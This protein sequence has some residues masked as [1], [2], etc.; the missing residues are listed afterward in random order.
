M[1]I[2]SRVGK[3]KFDAILSDCPARTAAE[4]FDVSPSNAI[5]PPVAL[6]EDILLVWYYTKIGRGQIVLQ[7][8]FWRGRTCGVGKLVEKWIQPRCLRGA[9]PAVYRR[10][11][12]S[13]RFV[14]LLVVGFIRWCFSDF[15]RL[16]RLCQSLDA[17]PRRIG[18]TVAWVP[19]L[20]LRRR[21]G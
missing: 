10:P 1:R 19:A 6:P 12:W 5:T 18:T 14:G 7:I 20:P 3:R 8:R 9:W 15:H 13:A 4:R 11:N 21:G 16:D 17:S 2:F